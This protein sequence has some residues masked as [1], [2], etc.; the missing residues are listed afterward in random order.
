[1]SKLS[2]D[3][4]DHLDASGDPFLREVVF[5]ARQLHLFS[6]YAASIMAWDHRKAR[7]LPPMPALVVSVVD[8]AVTPPYMMYEIHDR[9][10]GSELSL[11]RRGGHFW[12]LFSPEQ[13][14]HEFERWQASGNDRFENLV[15]EED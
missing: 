7:Q 1:L 12:P 15:H 14:V 11:V 6:N 3:L 5:G 8:D 4:N 10:R 9:L 13:F 2:T